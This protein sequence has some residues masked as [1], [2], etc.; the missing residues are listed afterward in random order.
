MLGSCPANK[1]PSADTMDAILTGLTK[2]Q[3]MLLLTTIVFGGKNCLDFLDFL[4]QEETELLKD[5]AQK[6]LTYPRKQRISFLV[7]EIKRI[8]T[9][10]SRADV[11]QGASP[12]QV[13]QALLNERPALVEITLRALPQPFAEQVDRSL[14][15]RKTKLR[16]E[17]LPEVLAVI[18]WK[19]QRQLE[20]IVPPRPFFTA[21]D[22]LIVPSRDLAF[23]ADTLGSQ[24]LA[25]LLV[26]LPIQ[27]C[28]SIMARLSPEQRVV[29]RKQLDCPETSVLHVQ[30]SEE[31]LSDSQE[32][33]A[34]E[35][36][37]LGIQAIARAC[38]AQSTEFSARV[39]EEHRDSFGRQL[40]EL[41]SLERQSGTRFPHHFLKELLGYMNVLAQ[42]GR[43]A[44]PTQRSKDAVRLA[45]KRLTS[46]L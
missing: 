24:S 6:I 39:I 22:L 21:T 2:S 27:E 18:R 37:R 19:F 16:R 30:V 44:I 43:I 41:V 45:Q 8:K 33:F 31:F 35:V 14:A 34:K 29:A 9:E 4:P 13:V 40:A 28:D 25:A 10:N 11:L 32:D 17:I 3:S 42:E 5:R 1:V 46:R 12:E 26:T 38:L 36:R 20:K 15:H 7:Q 23:V